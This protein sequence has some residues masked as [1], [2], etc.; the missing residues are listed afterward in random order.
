MGLLALSD[1]VTIPGQVYA[2]TAVFIL[3]LNSALNPLLYTISSI[4]ARKKM[5]SKS[6]FSSSAVYTNTRVISKIGNDAAATD[7]GPALA[8]ILM[9]TLPSANIWPSKAMSCLPLKCYRNQQYASQL[10]VKDIYNIAVDVI[11]GVSFLHDQGIIHTHIDEEH[12][13]VGMRAQDK[14]LHAYLVDLS[15]SKEARNK[16]KITFGNDIKKYGRFIASLLPPI[17]GDLEE[18]FD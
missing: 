17:H 16:S 3:P 9:S 11:A 18:H 12:V 10:T 7:F 5:K 14:C 6:G 15:D 13:V 8:P 4:K 1:T 2:W